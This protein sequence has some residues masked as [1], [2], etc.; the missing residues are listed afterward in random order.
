M[1][2]GVTLFVLIFL[3]HFK[4]DQHKYIFNAWPKWQKITTSYFP[5][6][7]NIFKFEKKYVCLWWICITKSEIMHIC[8]F[9]Q[10]YRNLISLK[11]ARNIHQVSSLMEIFAF[12]AKK[13]R[14]KVNKVQNFSTYILRIS[15][16]KP[17]HWQIPTFI[18]F[19]KWHYW[20]N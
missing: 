7:S 5:T 6:Y 12:K 1:G 8:R 10:S 4:Q 16:D 14:H 15:S 20:L 2:P 18:L 11:F 13:M 17:K 19:W 9:N 3:N